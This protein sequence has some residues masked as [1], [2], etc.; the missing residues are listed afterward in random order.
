MMAERLSFAII[1]FLVL[2]ITFMVGIIFMAMS[3]VRLNGI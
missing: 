3:I 2:R 1:Q